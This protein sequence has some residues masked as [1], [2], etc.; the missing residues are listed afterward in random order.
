MQYMQVNAEQLDYDQ[1]QLIVAFKERKAE[2]IAE[3]TGIEIEVLKGF[4]RELVRV[5][6]EKKGRKEQDILDTKFAASY[7]EQLKPRSKPLSPENSE[8]IQMIFG[9]FILGIAAWYD[10][11]TTTPRPSRPLTGVRAR[12]QRKSGSRD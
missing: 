5:V 6:I 2:E 1:D 4:L 3:K 9:N 12:R 7:A 8:A 10:Q 11:K